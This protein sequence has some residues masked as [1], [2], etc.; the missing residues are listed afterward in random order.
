MKESKTI[1]MYLRISKEDDNVNESNSIIHQ[2]KLIN[3][4]IEE[5]KDLTNLEMK[6]YIDDGYTGLDFNRDSFNNMIEDIKAGLVSSIIVKDISRFGRDYIEVAKYIES[7]LP[8]MNIRF[9]SVNDNY[10]TYTDGYVLPFDLSFKT[11]IYNY[12]S[13]DLS[14]K[15]S[16]AKKASMKQGNYISPYAFYGYKK[17]DSKNLLIDEDA[18]KIVKLIFEMALNDYSNME[19]AKHLNHKN[20]PTRSEY[21]SQNGMREEWKSKLIWTNGHVN[22]ILKDERY[23]GKLIQNK[24]NRSKFINSGKIIYL[25]KSKW[26]IKDHSFEPIVSEEIFKKV[27]ANRKKKVRYKSKQNIKVLIE[28]GICKFALKSSNSKDINY[29]CTTNRFSN[30]FDCS[31]NYISHN[32]LLK[33]INETIKKQVELCDIKFG[34]KKYKKDKLSL[35]AELK[36][37]IEQLKNEKL[38][39]YNNYL[40]SKLDIEEYKEQKISLDIILSEVSKEKADLEKIIE[41]DSKLLYNK[42]NEIL[43]KV[44][45]ISFTR[46]DD[47]LLNEIIEKVIVYNEKNIKII[48]K[49]KN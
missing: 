13:R 49:S 21:K 6:E 46:L 1:A 40:D 38:T 22:K 32:N 30:K 28:C 8:F 19:I 7:V 26:I 4:Y 47:G 41:N 27:N 35:L 42:D 44:R 39:L 16:S 31:K 45:G 2:R 10:D 5:Q 3:S 36:Q 48:F 17:G 34:K 37:K 18:S 23:T 15:I 24:Y 14:K 12:Y 20:I 11:I 29:Y 9:I 33:I 25:D 43:N